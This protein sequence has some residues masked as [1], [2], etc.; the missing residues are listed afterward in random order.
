MIN[1][2]VYFFVRVFFFEIICSPI[3]FDNLKILY[4]I[5][6]FEFWFELFRLIFIE[7]SNLKV[8]SRTEIPGKIKWYKR[9]N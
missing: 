9:I 2:A 7:L 1:S 6:A 8:Q 3:V 4:S 5:E